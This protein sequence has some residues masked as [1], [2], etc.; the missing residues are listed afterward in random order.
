MNA[1]DLKADPRQSRDD[2]VELGVGLEMALQP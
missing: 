2:G 1:L